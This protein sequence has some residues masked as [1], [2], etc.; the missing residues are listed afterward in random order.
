MKFNVNWVI[1]ILFLSVITIFVVTDFS[2]SPKDSEEIGIF[3]VILL[4]MYFAFGYS[5]AAKNKRAARK[6]KDL[7]NRKSVSK[8]IPKEEKQPSPK[9]KKSRFSSEFEDSA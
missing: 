7:R 2:N 8:E 9:Y 4:L 1:L 3:I 5:P 6:I